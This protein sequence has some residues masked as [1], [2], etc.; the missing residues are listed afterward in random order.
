MMKRKKAY[1]THPLIKGYF[2]SDFDEKNKRLCH[3]CIYQYF[4]EHAPEQPENLKEMQ[5]L[6]EQVYHGCAAG[7][8]DEVCDDVYWGKIH[9][10]EKYVITQKLG[11]WETDRSLVKT[12]FPEGDLSQ[13]PLVSEKSNQSLL[14]SEAGLVLLNTGRP[15]EAEKPL[16]TAIDIDIEVNQI[17]YASV[18]YIP[19]FGKM[20]N[21]AQKVSRVSEIFHPQQT[22]IIQF[23]ITSR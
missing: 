5:P 3:K 18:G 1:A 11:A 9:R 6:F 12:F 17:A 23:Y 8:Y 19:P 4:G 15:K 10:K 14:L 13:M 7:L 21:K 16:K 2:E 22:P 20:R